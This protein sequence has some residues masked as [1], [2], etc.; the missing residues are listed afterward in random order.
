MGD[1]I[2]YITQFYVDFH[3][4]TKVIPKT[5][6]E[7]MECYKGFERCSYVMRHMNACA[8]K[9]HM[10]TNSDG[11]ER[12]RGNCEYPC[13]SLSSLSTVLVSDS[14]VTHSIPRRYQ[15]LLGLILMTL[16]CRSG[17]GSL[18]Q[19]TDSESSVVHND[20]ER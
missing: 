11:L 5:N 2:T 18:L 8:L 20:Q 13:L 19:S 4:P 1:H 10:G 6:P 16:C 9:F 14:V 15:R 17:S 12:H 3:K 7:N